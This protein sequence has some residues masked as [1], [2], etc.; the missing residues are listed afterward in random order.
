M[1]RWRLR[2]QLLLDAPGAV[3]GFVTDVPDVQEIFFRHA[4]EL[5]HGV[6]ASFSEEAADAERQTDPLDV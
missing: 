1:K 4:D 6:D 5:T 2:C 3:D